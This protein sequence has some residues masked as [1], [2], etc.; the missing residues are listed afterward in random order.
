MARRSPQEKK[1]LS[2]AKD[3][4]N[5]YGENDKSSRK[6]IRRSKRLPNRADRRREH[7]ALTQAS[8]PR[9][10]A[11]AEAAEQQLLSKPSTW[12]SRG[13][14]KAPDQPLGEHVEE[15]L[16]RRVRLGIDEATTGQNRID[17]V[18]QLRRRHGGR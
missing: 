7:Q 18:R 16:R 1:Q 12:V 3:R 4:H 15:R 11:A 8:G 5:T 2:Y 17:R 13:W 6:N 9:L 10:D 14:R